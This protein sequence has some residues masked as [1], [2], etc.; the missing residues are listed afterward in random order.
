AP[1]HIGHHQIGQNQ[2]GSRLERIHRLAS[3]G[4]G[5]NCISFIAQNG[6]D[7]VAHG[8][9]ILDQQN[10][11]AVFAHVQRLST[12]RFLSAV[13]GRSLLASFALASGSFRWNVAPCPGSDSTV[14]LPPKLSTKRLT[15]AKP[16]PLPSF[17][18]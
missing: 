10:M 2:I 17:L 14:T 18:D 5:L 7:G 8:G 13:A 3:I 16:M 12:A 6:G 11:E 15:N 4:G 1:I 9:I